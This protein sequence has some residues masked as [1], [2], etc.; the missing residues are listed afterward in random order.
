MTRP[1]RRNARDRVFSDHAPDGEDEVQN[2]SG[3]PGQPLTPRA[4]TPPRPGQ[5]PSPRV[6]RKTQVQISAQSGETLDQD[7]AK[8]LSRAA[9]H[10]AQVRGIIEGSKDPAGY[11]GHLFGVRDR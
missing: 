8:G 11:L 7:M 4:V 3:H 2:V 6:G 5:D 9:Q 10:R 1:A